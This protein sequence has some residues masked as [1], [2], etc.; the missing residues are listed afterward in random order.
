MTKWFCGM[1]R[2]CGST[3]RTG[4]F[5]GEKIYTPVRN[6][7]YNVSNYSCIVSLPGWKS[8]ASPSKS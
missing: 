8:I 4:P 3:R 2:A 5:K 6:P 7:L 1:R